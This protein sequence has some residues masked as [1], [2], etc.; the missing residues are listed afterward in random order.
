MSVPE[1]VRK[2]AQL[3]RAEIAFHNDLY[4][5]KDSP[6]ISDAAFD[7]ILRKLSELEEKYPELREIGRAHV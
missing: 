6:Q 1:K 5:G 4:H 2:T 3:L 7:E